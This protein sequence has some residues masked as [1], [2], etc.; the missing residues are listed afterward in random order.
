MASVAATPEAKATACVA[1]S[2]EA[3]LPSSAER[4][5]LETREY[6]WPLWSPGAAWTYVL[7]R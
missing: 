1:P 7:V 3:R 4:V 2:S 5:G 6:S